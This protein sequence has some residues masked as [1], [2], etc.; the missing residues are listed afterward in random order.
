[1]EFTKTIKK[2]IIHS[3]VL[4]SLCTCH[5]DKNLSDNDIYP[6]LQS[7][8]EDYYRNYDIEVTDVLNQFELQLM[9]EGRLSDT[10]GAAY[11]T[12]LRSLDTTNYFTLP[13]HTEDFNKILLY[14]NPN[15]ILNCAV[16]VFLLDSANI[17]NTHFAKIEKEIHQK[18]TGEEDISIHYFFQVYQ[19]KLSNDEIR[20]PYIKQNILLLLYRW[21][22]ISQQKT[23]E[24]AGNS[25]SK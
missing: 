12:L 2:L 13:L 23:N 1:M 11:K 18:V 21:Y 19:T 3:L 6:F 20:R 4:F 5:S 22:I 15:D 16:N 17:S 8:Y 14:K 9:D 25:P 24:E 10:T 7:C